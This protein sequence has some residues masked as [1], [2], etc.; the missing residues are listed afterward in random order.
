MEYKNIDRH[1]SNFNIAGFTYWDG[2]ISIENLK[3]G[4]ILQMVRESDNKFDPNAVAIYHE[5]NKLGYVPRGENELIAKF[6][7]LGYSEIFDLRVQR[8]SLDA[9]P[10]KQVGVVLFIKMA[11]NVLLAKE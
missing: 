2:C 4:T 8:L 3:I 10:E 6:I 9:H 11:N 7:D 1:F 5:Q